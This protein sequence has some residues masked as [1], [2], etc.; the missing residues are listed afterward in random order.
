[1]IG[2]CI[3]ASGLFHLC[4][5]AHGLS[6]SDFIKVPW[7]NAWA[8]FSRDTLQMLQEM[9]KARGMTM[10]LRVRNG[11]AKLIL[12]G[13]CEDTMRDFLSTCLAEAERGQDM[14]QAR[15][16]AFQSKV[17]SLGFRVRFKVQTKT[18]NLQRMSL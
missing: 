5:R 3:F 4:R 8:S 16:A 12:G 11:G 6:E 9:A 2:L 18:Y 14:S 13:T 15:G 17:Q 1:M 7:P 10:K